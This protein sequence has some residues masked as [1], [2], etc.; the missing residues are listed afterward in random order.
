MR[1]N[2]RKWDNAM[3]PPIAAVPFLPPALS[4]G[5]ESRL[6][7]TRSNR[8]VAPDLPPTTFPVASHHFCHRGSHFLSS[9]SSTHIWS[10][11]FPSVP[12]VT[13]RKGERF[14]PHRH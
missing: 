3:T 9:P 10:S 7:P 4:F 6:R 14:A 13:D 5:T 8:F 12:F 11:R 1:G 2:E